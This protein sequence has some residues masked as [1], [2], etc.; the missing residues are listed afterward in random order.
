MKSLN[1][2]MKWIFASALL[3][4]L[5]AYLM[6]P[7]Q[8]GHL[9]EPESPGAVFTVSNNLDA[10]AGS[11]RQAIIDANAMA[12]TDTIQ[13]QIGMG[14]VTISHSTSLPDITGPVIIDGTTQPG[15]SGTPLITLGGNFTVG[16]KITGGG[17]TVKA[18]AFTGFVNGILL[19]NAGGNIITG[20]WIGICPQN[21]TAD[22]GNFG[23]GILINN[24]PNN[25]IGGSTAA[26]RNLIGG[27]A[28]GVEIRGAASSG[29]VVTGNY[30]GIL[31]NDSI[32]KNGDSGVFIN[33]APNNRIGGTI[34]A[35][36]NVV[37]GN[38]L[39]GP[40]TQ[41]L[42]GILI[43]GAAATG[44]I[45]QG[46][47][48]GTKIDGMTSAA[49][50]AD[51]NNGSNNVRIE[52][53]A[54]NTI[55]G[56]VGTTPGGACTGAC[57][58]ISGNR[59]NGGVVITGSGATGNSVLGNF[60]GTNVAGTINVANNV[61][62]TITGTA[63]NNT[64]GGTTAA[65]RNLI[66]NGM[67]LTAGA[68]MNTV[69]GNFIGTDTTGNIAIG[70]GTLFPNILVAVG[71]DAS[72]NN[73]IGTASGTTLGG[74]CTGGCNLISGNN[75]SHGVFI[76]G[77]GSMGNRV[78]YNYIGLNAAGT[79]ALRNGGDA[80][81]LRNGANNTT[82]GRLIATTPIQM[83]EACAANAPLVIRC[84]QDDVTGDW[85]Q[86]NDLTGEYTWNNCRSRL[87]PISGQGEIKV[88]SAGIGLH[89]TTVH[90]FVNISTGRG[91]A[92]IRTAGSRFDM[93][94]SNVPNS[95]CV[96]PMEGMQTI[97]GDVSSG[98]NNDPNPPNHNKYNFN[99]LGW[100]SNRLSRLSLP[101]SDGYVRHRAGNFNVYANLD[102]A[103]NGG[104]FAPIS[105]AS[106]TDNFI[107]GLK[108][109][110]LN[111]GLYANL[112]IDLNDNQILDPN[113]NGDGDSGANRTQ[114][115]P[116]D[117]KFLFE[118][119]G[120][121]RMTGTFNS[122]QNKRFLIKV[123]AKQLVDS[124]DGRLTTGWHD[125]GLSFEVMTD[126]N[127]NTPVN[128]LFTQS[129]SSYL[130][131]WEELAV[132][133]TLIN[134]VPIASENGVTTV[135][136]VLGDTSE[137]SAPAVVLQPKFDFDED[138]K[139]DIA[140]Y[141]PGASA[142]AFSFWYV[143][144]SSDF[145]FRVVQF[146]NSEDKPVTGDYQGDGLADFAVFRPSTGTWYFSRITGNPSTNFNAVQWGVSTDIPVPGDYDA[147]G[148]ND[149]AIFRPSDGSWWIRRSLDGSFYVQQ[150][151]LATD[152]VAPA[153]YDGD[154]DTDIA[155]YRNG[156]WYIS[157]C[158]GCAPVY[159]QF[160]L[161]SDVPVPGDYDGDGRDDVAVWRPSTGVW[162]LQQSTAGFAALQF[163]LPTDK[164]VA[165]D[166]DADGK[167]DIAVW[168]PSEGI[169]YVLRSEQGFFAIQWGLSTDIPI[170]IF[171]NQ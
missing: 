89:S 112:Q 7:H 106:G 165:G 51:D 88:N 100:S 90:A 146:G 70:T 94:D 9:Q 155:V 5:A 62:V 74:A 152:K 123:Y 140:V 120:V 95:T 68:G 58:V 154:G 29:N 122:T 114:N 79:T 6:L 78:D 50:G 72:P 10:G 153:D 1:T 38:G 134:E 17:S 4:A 27:N 64:V 26:E 28:D 98:V 71:I 54:N 15:F 59:F 77:V 141:R 91:S 111:P 138:G 21:P 109:N 47:Y 168:R 81:T 36:R 3:S 11:F 144:N 156:T 60:I 121:I 170:G 83:K 16:L 67:V 132:T 19:E 159:A 150:W 136:D 31:A 124:A 157:P 116:V 61:G 92:S 2:K 117:V 43:S 148:A 22:C 103:T 171:P 85:I 105:V 25:Q 131:P 128:R 55:G 87:G 33:G 110:A 23:D 46:N 75:A 53:A 48:I 135:V 97:V 142:G 139:T 130:H 93:Q 169:W 69:Q 20:C 96:C 84:I 108:V 14:A 39:G 161:A 119:D 115:H 145:T 35:E 158:P 143:L 45:V 37:S 49:G 127:G 76:T 104:N 137:F 56:T 24:S 8:R 167:S 41:S 82:I 133:A 52:G 149:A 101:L 99:S 32:K 66:T 160:G 30:I 44:N 42:S 125:L 151:G 118:D 163:G 65:G 13:F 113:D 57:N 147:D 40:F 126:L 86:F 12:G 18:V 107:Y 166:F 63:S 129:D 34:A 102:I 80:I 162:Y 73:F 164:A